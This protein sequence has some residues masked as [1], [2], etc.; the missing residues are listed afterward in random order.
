VRLIEQDL[1]SLRLAGAIPHSTS[2]GGF[3]ARADIES[4]EP[5]VREALEAMF[6]AISSS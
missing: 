2:L 5:S 6:T 3:S 1:G 4:V